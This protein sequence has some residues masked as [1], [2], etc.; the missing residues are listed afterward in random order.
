MIEQKNNI[1]VSKTALELAEKLN[2]VFSDGKKSNA[3]FECIAAVA[4]QEMAE[5]KAT[6][7]QK[8]HVQN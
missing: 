6:H 4:T 8:T 2:A 5:W 1:K 3:S 7:Q